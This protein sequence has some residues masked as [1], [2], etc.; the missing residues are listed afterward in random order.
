MYKV[1]NS[2]VFCIC[3]WFVCI[4]FIGIYNIIK[5]D[6]FIFKVFNFYYI[7]LFFKCNKRDGWVL[8]GGVVFVIIGMVVK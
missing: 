7:N 8:F 6:F 3:L 2:F 5:F 1:G 4:V